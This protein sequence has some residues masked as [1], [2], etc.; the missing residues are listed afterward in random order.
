MPA[1]ELEA[2]V[3][4]TATAIAEGAPLSVRAAK[5]SVTAAVGGSETEDVERADTAIA[6]CWASEDFAEG[7]K[8]FAE[9]RPPVFRGR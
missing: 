6:A 9:K 8:A 4:A 7:R 3:T 2:S 1:G 5:A